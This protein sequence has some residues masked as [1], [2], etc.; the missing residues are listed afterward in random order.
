VLG[1][2]MPGPAMAERPPGSGARRERSAERDAWTV[3][4]AVSRL[5]P[6][7]LAALLVRYG[8]GVAILAEAA[9]PGGVA[10]LA[11]TRSEPGLDGTIHRRPINLALATAIARA[12][13]DTALTLGRIRAAGI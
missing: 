11:E 6:V 1:V 3:L 8:S 10:R 13:N 12:A 2:G 4:S 7:G 9:S 5:G